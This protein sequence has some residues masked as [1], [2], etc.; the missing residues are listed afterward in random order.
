MQNQL[1]ECKNCLSKIIPKVGHT[2]TVCHVFG[3]TSILMKRT[4]YLIKDLSKGS[5]CLKKGPLEALEYHLIFAL[6]F[7][8]QFKC[9]SPAILGTHG[10]FKVFIFK[11]SI[12]NS[13]LKIICLWTCEFPAI[14][15]SSS[16]IIHMKSTCQGTV[17]IFQY[18]PFGSQKTCDCHHDYLHIW[19]KKV[20]VVL[21]KSLI[22]LI[23]LSIRIGF[24]NYVMERF[25]L[26]RMNYVCIPKFLIN[27][28]KRHKYHMQSTRNHVPSLSV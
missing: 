17:S 3:C 20:G 21:T 18:V 4:W 10:M 12:S 19:L 11:S 7:G 15:L 24:T 25:C 1:L 9:F 8:E 22:R 27:M 28:Y 23:S 13:F 14:C 5:V 2:S 6:Y 16:P 26:D